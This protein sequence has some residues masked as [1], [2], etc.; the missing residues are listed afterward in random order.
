MNPLFYIFLSIPFIGNWPTGYE[1]L[2]SEVENGNLKKIEKLI[3][4][5]LYL[6][7]TGVVLYELLF[8]ATITEQNEVA[9]LLIDEGANIHRKVINDFIK[10]TNDI[11]SENFCNIGNE[12]ICFKVKN[13]HE[14]DNCGIE[15]SR[16]IL[17]TAK[18]YSAQVGN[19][20]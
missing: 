16:N 18:D 19:M 3:S 12:T 8:T 7:E 9:Q 4:K 15:L 10:K 1:E 11:D 2:N 13:I 20:L 14:F 5:H 17:L 6:K